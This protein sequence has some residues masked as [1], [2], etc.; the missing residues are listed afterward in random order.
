MGRRTGE[1]IFGVL[2]ILVGVGVIVAVMFGVAFPAIVPGAI[3]AVVIGWA[4]YHRTVVRPSPYGV[5]RPEESPPH[6]D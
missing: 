6:P 2:A 5:E 3:A 4:I 1:K